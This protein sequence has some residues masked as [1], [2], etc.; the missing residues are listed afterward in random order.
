LVAR[1][2]IKPVPSTHSKTSR[3][4]REGREPS[5]HRFR[6]ETETSDIAHRQRV[7]RGSCVASGS[8]RLLR[9]AA[10]THPAS[11]FFLSPSRVSRCRRILALC[12]KSLA[13]P[14]GTHKILWLPQPA[15]NHISF[16]QPHTCATF[17][18][19]KKIG[20][21]HRVGK[22]ADYGIY[23]ARLAAIP[24]R[25]STI[26]IYSTIGM[27]VETFIR[28]MESASRLRVPRLLYAKRLLTSGF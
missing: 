11:R 12:M 3:S 9:P 26:S 24:S 23:L 21:R 17:P 6:R 7:A 1:S 14:V 10:A 25:N 28:F 19:V 2:P 16:W 27:V 18:R 13:L 15:A 20:T 22:P 5:I 4:Q 8:A